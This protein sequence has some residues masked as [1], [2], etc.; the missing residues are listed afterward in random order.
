MEEPAIRDSRMEDTSDAANMTCHG[1]DGRSANMT[2]TSQPGAYANRLYDEPGFVVAS[3][4]CRAREK[5]RRQE[6][7][8]GCARRGVGTEGGDAGT[9]EEAREQEGREW[10]QEAAAQARAEDSEADWQE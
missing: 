8:G 7:R 4:A 5:E 9:D 6:G 3:C 10:E 1:E 2:R